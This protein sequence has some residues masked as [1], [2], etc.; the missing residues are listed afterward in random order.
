VQRVIKA[1]GNKNGNVILDF[2]QAQRLEEQHREE[3]RQ[4]WE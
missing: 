3:V 2:E 4:G 1:K